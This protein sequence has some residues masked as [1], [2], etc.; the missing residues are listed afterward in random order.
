MHV[1]LLDGPPAHYGLPWQGAAT[2]RSMEGLAQALATA[3]ATENADGVEYRILRCILAWKYCA[4][5]TG[6]APAWPV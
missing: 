1:D 5:R 4:A 2:N 6:S 3:H